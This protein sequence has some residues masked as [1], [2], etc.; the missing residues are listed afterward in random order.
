MT[1]VDWLALAFVAFTA[2]LGLKKGLIGSA[3][4][5]A[6]IVVGAIVGSR[7][8]PQ[9][10]TGGSNSAYTPLAALAGAAFGALLFETLGRDSLVVSD[11]GLR[12]GLLLERFGADAPAASQRV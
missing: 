5:L 2:L 12:H 4:S 9:L 3:L 10:L 1:N 8:A 6:G 11:R 7:L